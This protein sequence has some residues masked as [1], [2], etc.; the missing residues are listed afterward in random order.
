MLPFRLRVAYPLGGD[1]SGQSG[2][3]VPLIVGTGT[4]GLKATVSEF[5][6]GY[7]ISQESQVL[8]VA[9]NSGTYT[10]SFQGQRLPA[11]AVINDMD[12]FSTTNK[13]YGGQV[14]GRMRFEG[15][16]WLL[17]FTLTRDGSA[18]TILAVGTEWR[19]DVAAQAGPHLLLHRR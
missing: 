16:L 3:Q 5:A 17:H 11:G 14:G 18:V 6:P 19:Y 10:L 15:P 1:L 13:F 9:L 2:Q 12:D 4:G 7:G 8:A